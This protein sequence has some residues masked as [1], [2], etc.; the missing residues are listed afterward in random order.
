MAP[1]E[2]WRRVGH[3]ISDA[4]YK[5]LTGEDGYFDTRIVFVSESGPR[6]QRRRVL[7][8]MDQDGANFQVLTDGSAQ[9]FTP[10]FSATSQEITYMALRDIVPN[11]SNDYDTIN[12]WQY[13]GLATEFHNLDFVGRFDY[14]H[15][16]PFIVSLTGEWV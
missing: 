7:T 16:E 4:V 5:R 6:T 1:G 2:N 10:R 14:L 9:I 11:A 12:Q 15:F 8:V 13:Y 3:K